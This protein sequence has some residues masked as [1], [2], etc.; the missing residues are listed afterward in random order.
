M[1]SESQLRRDIC[2]IGKRIWTRGYVAA[3]DGNITVRLEDGCLLATPTGVSKG[4]MT[5]DM[6]IKLDPEGNKIAGELNPSSELKMHRAV[7]AMRPDVKA[8][9]HAHPPTATGFAVA[10]IP[11][12]KMLLPE[13]IISLGWVPIA[14]YGTPSTEELGD[15]LKELLNHHD[16]MLLENHG[17]LTVGH[18]LTNAYFKMETIEL[19]AQISLSAC[20]LGREREISPANV[21]KLMQVR[22]KLGVQGMHPA[23]SS[24]PRMPAAE[25]EQETCNH[26]SE[27]RLAD[28]VARVTREVLRNIKEM[29]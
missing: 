15:V 9:V 25:S 20:L 18:N 4:F 22:K 2:D 27:S 29:D 26:L 5:P 21:E 12:N 3:N 13:V 7:Y 14:K 16:A 11:M 8:V 1:Q 19:A 28:V 6:I 10:G 24:T 23:L 17:A